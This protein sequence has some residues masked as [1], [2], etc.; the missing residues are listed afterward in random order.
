MHRGE[1]PRR[2]STS[3]SKVLTWQTI[4]PAFT[5]GASSKALHDEHVVR[6]VAAGLTRVDPDAFEGR[7]NLVALRNSPQT[8]RWR[9]VN[10]AQRREARTVDARRGRP[11]ISVGDTAR[12]LGTIVERYEI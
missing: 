9:R 2:G 3:Y 6:R 12:L 5:L 11:Q 7:R 1:R 8:R 10:G 4:R